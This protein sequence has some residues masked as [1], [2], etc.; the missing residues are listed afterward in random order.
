M[1]KLS[2]KQS[3]ISRKQPNQCGL[4]C[5]VLPVLRKND[6]PEKKAVHLPRAR[7]AERG[8]ARRVR[9]RL[10]RVGGAAAEGAGQVG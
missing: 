1:L 7:V 6:L 2:G 5:T 9:G 4:R 10:A 3:M 8:R